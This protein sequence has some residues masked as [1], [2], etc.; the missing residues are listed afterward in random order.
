[1]NREFTARVW[2]EGDWLVAQCLKV[3]VASQGRTEEDALV[4]LEE[5]LSL[6][7]EPPRAIGGVLR[8]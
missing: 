6:H 2:R 4:N 3:D 1:M 7:F 5:A 8:G